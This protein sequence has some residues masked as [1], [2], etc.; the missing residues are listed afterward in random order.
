[1]S[2]SRVVINQTLG[3]FCFWEPAPALSSFAR[4][5]QLHSGMWSIKLI[6]LSHSVWFAFRR[7]IHNMHATHVDCV[8]LSKE[9][10]KIE[11]SYTIYKLESVALYILYLCLC[12]SKSHE[13]VCKPI[14]LG[15]SSDDCE[16]CWVEPKLPWQH[17]QRFRPNHRQRSIDI[18][19]RALRR[20]TDQR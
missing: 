4:K 17:R 11:S 3:T 10:F 20:P 18:V 8:L 16:S 2:P 14:L 7:G 6:S 1:M 13:C 15:E 5:K 12:P 19:L 9:T